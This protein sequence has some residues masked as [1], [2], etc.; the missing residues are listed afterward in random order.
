MLHLSSRPVH[1]YV[2]S[3]FLHNYLPVAWC[4]LTAWG[5]ILLSPCRF[6]LPRLH[7]ATSPTLRVTPWT[8]RRPTG[9][10]WSDTQWQ[11][12]LIGDC[13]CVATGRASSVAPCSCPSRPPT[14]IA[15]TP[16]PDWWARD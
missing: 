15:C 2:P 12:P 3:D 5:R 10:G 1:R 16:W 14:H 11:P 13:Q 7:P 9:N 4:C 6:R 8:N